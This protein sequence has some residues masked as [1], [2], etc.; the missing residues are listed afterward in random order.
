VNRFGDLFVIFDDRSVHMLDVNSGTVTRVANDRD[1][2]AGQIDRDDNANN[3]LMIP[4]VDQCVAAGLSLRSDQ[5]FAY[6]VPP[7]LGG[8]Y[9]I[10]NVEPFDLAVNYSLMSHICTQVEKLPEWHKSQAGDC[11]CSGVRN[12][13]Y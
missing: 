4:L 11:P 1:D 2:F 12:R 8:Q 5:C 3:W 10:A 13:R 9:P 6:R 7:I